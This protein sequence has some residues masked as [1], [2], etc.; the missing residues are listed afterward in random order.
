MSGLS[1]SEVTERFQEFAV[2]A[3]GKPSRVRIPGNEEN[4]LGT[5]EHTNH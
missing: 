1:E 2:F 4:G 5:F 3:D